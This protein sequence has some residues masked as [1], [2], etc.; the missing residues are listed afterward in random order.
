M[1]R[2][3]WG[4]LVVATVLG[5]ASP[6]GA[7]VRLG[8]NVRIGGYDFSGRR[9]GAVHVERVRRLPGPPGCR[10]VRRG[11]Y[12]RGDGTLVRGPMQ[13]CHLPARPH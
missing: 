4:G 9:A 13:V 6:A 3:H 7:E 5:L 2:A 1:G 11:R 10:H 12:R 8:G